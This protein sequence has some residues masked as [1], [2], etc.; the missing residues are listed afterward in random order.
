MVDGGSAEIDEEI[1]GEGCYHL[2]RLGLTAEQI[3]GHFETTPSRVLDLAVRY[4]AK[5]KSG[6][7]VAG[8]FDS[9]FWA[10]VKKEAE[11]DVKLTF[12][13]EKGFHHAWKSE[14]A[15]LDGPALMSVFEASK[16]FLN[17]DPN[18]RFLDFPPPAGY[19]PLAMDR[20]MRKS[21]TII[22]ALLEEKWKALG[23]PSPHGD[24]ET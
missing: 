11:G 23:A 19:D 20:E 14:L 4:E 24:S 17:A 5:L 22:G 15:K 8:D 12:L 7:V 18:Q 13:S 16:D 1:L 10:D 21:V 9:T 3:A 6:E 2:L